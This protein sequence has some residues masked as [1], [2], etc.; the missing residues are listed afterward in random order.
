M[1][2]L[3]Y[4]ADHFVDD[5][6]LRDIFVVDAGLDEWGLVMAALRA[7]GW[8]L[9]I[10][11]DDEDVTGTSYAADVFD[12][13]QPGQAATAVME[14]RV[15]A[16]WFSAHF[17]A[18]SRLEFTFEPTAVSGPDDFRSLREFMELLAESTRREVVMTMETPE[19]EGI[20]RLLSTRL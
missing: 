11:L 10:S 20:P 19:H 15:G 7:S 9:S 17:F 5:G 3:D 8:P 12:R 4:H 13:L 14:V 18:A 6:A 1:S 16:I 2:R